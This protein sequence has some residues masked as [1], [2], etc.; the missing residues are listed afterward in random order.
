MIGLYEYQDAFLSCKVSLAG[1]E[2]EAWGSFTH[3][4]TSRLHCGSAFL[5]RSIGG[6]VFI[7]WVAVVFNYGLCDGFH[8]EKIPCCLRRALAQVLRECIVERS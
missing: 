3:H 4:G 2:P 7:I 6:L 1:S 5:V 8:V